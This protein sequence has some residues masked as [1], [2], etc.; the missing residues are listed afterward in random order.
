MDKVSKPLLSDPTPHTPR[1]FFQSWNSTPLNWCQIWTIAGALRT[2]TC[3]GVREN[4]FDPPPNDSPDRWAVDLGKPRLKRWHPHF[5]IFSA[6]RLHPKIYQPMW[7]ILHHSLPVLARLFA[8][9]HPEV[10]SP[11][12]PHHPDGVHRPESIAH[13]LFCT[14]VRPVWAWAFH[15]LS[16][17]TDMPAVY[18]ANA[19]LGGAEKTLMTAFLEEWHTKAPKPFDQL[20]HELIAVVVY[21]IVKHRNTLSLDNIRSNDSRLARKHSMAVLRIVVQ[22]FRS[23]VRDRFWEVQRRAPKVQTKEEEDKYFKRLGHFK[24]SYGA[25][26]ILGE[27]VRGESEH[28]LD[29]VYKDSKIHL[30]YFPADFELVDKFRL[31]SELASVA[32]RTRS[33]SAACAR[34]DR[35]HPRRPHNPG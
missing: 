27:V 1:F 8:H 23:V 14:T 26:G 11:H 16:L 32:R 6:L 21:G 18:R 19:L 30:V 4:L 9:N 25:N 34:A 33:E 28:A 13:V 5:E 29:F 10:L 7:L 3:K 2:I 35:G 31:S 20:W 17:I 24:K 15:L 22:T 12:C